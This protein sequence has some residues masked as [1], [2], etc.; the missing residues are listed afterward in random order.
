MLIFVI[1]LGEL[2]LILVTKISKFVPKNADVPVWRPLAPR[3][4]DLFFTAKILF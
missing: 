2:S 1:I 3:R 4:G